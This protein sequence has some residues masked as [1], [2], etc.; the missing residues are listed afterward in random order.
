MSPEASWGRR[1]GGWWVG[2]EGAMVQGWG[3]EQGDGARCPPGNA[4]SAGSLARQQL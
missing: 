4:T 1:V 3:D 2:G